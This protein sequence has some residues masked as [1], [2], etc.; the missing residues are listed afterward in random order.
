MRKTTPKETSNG[1]IRARK[2]EL[3]ENQHVGRTPYAG[4][5]H[6]NG[7]P[8]KDV[9]YFELLGRKCLEMDKKN[10]N[11]AIP[12]NYGELDRNV[13]E[14]AKQVAMGIDEGMSTEDLQQF[15]NTCIDYKS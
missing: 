5:K 13:C 10:P 12:T 2:P 8:F 4:L 1:M 14:V 7:R 3:F 15:I 11:K 9:E 6:Q